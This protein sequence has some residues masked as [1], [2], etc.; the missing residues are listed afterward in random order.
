MTVYCKCKDDQDRDGDPGEYWCNTCG[1]EI[2]IEN[3][4]QPELDITDFEVGRT[5]GGDDE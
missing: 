5:E 2:K 1:R 3:E 4:D